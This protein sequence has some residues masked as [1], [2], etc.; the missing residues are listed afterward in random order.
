M[1]APAFV[2]AALVG[3]AVAGAALA[4]ANAPLRPTSATSLA[5]PT[6]EPAIA[7]DCELGYRG[8]TVCYFHV[9]D[10]KQSIAWYGEKLGLTEVVTRNEAIGWC[11]LQSPTAG[12]AIGLLQS[13]AVDPKGGATLVFGVADVDDARTQLE[14]MKVK[15]AGPTEVHPGYVKLA[16]F[17]DPDGHL[18]TLSQSLAPETGATKSAA[19][20][21]TR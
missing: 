19:G 17:T 12:L 14:E 1:S 6:G 10:L 2:T 9:A 18:I 16:Y 21:G 5:V 13:K 8:T 7:V 3:G 11:E 4:P 15:F 20:S